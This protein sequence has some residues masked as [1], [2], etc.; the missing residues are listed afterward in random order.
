MQINLPSDI[1]NIALAAVSSGRV[2]SVAEFVAAA[3]KQSDLSATA[4]QSNGSTGQSLSQDDRCDH[5][6]E[7]FDQFLAE[8]VTTNP[9]FDDSRENT[10]PD[11]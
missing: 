7:Q 1:E 3:V 8:Q 9:N 10:Y 6:N 11:C 5:W 2:A 4:T